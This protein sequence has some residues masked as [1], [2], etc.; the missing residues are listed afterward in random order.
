VNDAFLV[1]SVF[2]GNT[3]EVLLNTHPKRVRRKGGL[4]RLMEDKNQFRGGQM[5]SP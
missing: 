5:F 2:N 4:L 1:V 3:I